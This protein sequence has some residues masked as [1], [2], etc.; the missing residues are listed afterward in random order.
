MQSAILIIDDEVD[1]ASAMKRLLKSDGHQVYTAQNADTAMQVLSNEKINVVISDQ[2]MPEKRGHQLLSEIS[3]IYPDIS[4]MMMS[5]YCDFAAITCGLNDANIK[6]FI[7][8]PWENN[9]VKQMVNSLID[10]QSEHPKQRSPSTERF[11]KRLHKSLKEKLIKHYMQPIINTA[12]HSIYGAEFL[13]RPFI[14]AT[15][16]EDAEKF[17]GNASKANQLAT[18]AIDQLNTIQAECL[19]AL[20]DNFMLS[21]NISPSLL[22]DNQFGD[23]LN[24]WI[25]Q[26]IVSS[27]IN[28][29]LEITESEF[30]HGDNLLRKRLQALRDSGVKIALDDFCTGYSSLDHLRTLPVDTIKLDKSFI[31]NIHKDRTAD[32]IVSSMINLANTLDMAV[33]AEGVEK[34][35]QASQLNALGCHLQQGYLYRP[36]IPI[37]KFLQTY[38]K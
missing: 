37:D 21:I 25:A 8:K 27:N 34:Q 12:D 38:M 29:T 19:T 31:D 9:E 11:T 23:Y 15:N 35:E 5:G 6:K 22:F 13:V 26:N 33:I 3:C 1:V 10:E 18:I 2:R 7:Q 14:N 20:H 30:I 28:L 24:N 17:I 32:S 36:A 16:I 4:C